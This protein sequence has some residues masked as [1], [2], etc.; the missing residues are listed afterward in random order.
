MFLL[1]LQPSALVWVH[2]FRSFKPNIVS[3]TVGFPCKW[4][5]SS[6]FIKLPLQSKKKKKKHCAYCYL[7]WMF[8]F[9]RGMIYVLSVTLEGG[10]HIHLVTRESLS[11]F[12]FSRLKIYL[13]F[14]AASAQPF[15]VR[16]VNVIW[17]P[18]AC[19]AQTVFKGWCWYFCNLG[20]IF[21]INSLR[22]VRTLTLPL[23]PTGS[24]GPWLCDGVTR[25][26]STCID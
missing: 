3:V 2:T 26:V 11:V 18:E 1:I 9:H 21:G 19:T 7:T 23:P 16:H 12:T 10:L 15:V 13:W 14:I 6:S 5:A 17:K 22:S 20:P 4:L 25:N 24:N 8:A